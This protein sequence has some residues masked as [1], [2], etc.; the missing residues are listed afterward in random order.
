ME[1]VHLPPLFFLISSPKTRG[2]YPA[3]Y[4]RSDITSTKSTVHTTLKPKMSTFTIEAPQLMGVTGDSCASCGS[5]SVPL[6]D[7]PCHESDDFHWRDCLTKTFYNVSDEVVRC[8]H[9]SCRQLAGFKPLDLLEYGLHLNNDFYDEERIDKIREQLDCIHK[10]GSRGDL[11]KHP[12]Y[13]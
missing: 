6:Y 12:R 1:Y 3:R 7:L 8:P 2:K 5:I 4:Q 10:R 13:G 9:S 11:T